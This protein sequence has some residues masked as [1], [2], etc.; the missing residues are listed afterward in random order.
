MLIE[1][2]SD[3]SGGIVQIDVGESNTPFDVHLELLCTCS[4]YFDN[5]FSSRCDEAITE[6]FI[7]FPDDDPQVFAQIILWMYRGDNSVEEL[8]SKELDFLIRLWILA[9]KLEMKDL[10]KL[11]MA[12]CEKKSG[13]MGQDTVNYIYSHTL[14][15]SQM[16]RLAVDIGVRSA[17]TKD[18]EKEKG[19]FSRPFLEDLCAELIKKR[20]DADL[21][22]PLRNFPED[23]HSTRLSPSTDLEEQIFRPEGEV[24]T[25]KPATVAQ[26]NSR[27]VK[28]GKI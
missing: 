20:V 16:R 6:P 22:I 7:F 24:D 27:R 23:R 15:E 21:P 9:G 12:I 11:V 18:F 10:Q 13:H 26:M 5:K 17:T 4:S 25:K 28:R 1:F 19:K 3:L 14:P 2:A 8:K